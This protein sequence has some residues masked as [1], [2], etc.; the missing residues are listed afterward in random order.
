MKHP[1][2]TEALTLAAANA[3]GRL[4]QGCGRNENGS[5]SVVGT[6]ACHWIKKSQ[7]QKGKIAIYNRSVADIRPERAEPNQ[8]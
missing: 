2:Y 3:Y 1:K 7:V 5:Q 8:V 6:N 4:F